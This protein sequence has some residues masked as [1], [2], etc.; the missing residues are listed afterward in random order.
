VNALGRHD[1][2]TAESLF[3]VVVAHQTLRSGSLRHSLYEVRARLAEVQALRADYDAAEKSLAAAARELEAWRSELSDRDLRLAVAQA[4][5]S[6]GTVGA[7]LPA[8]LSMFARS[9]RVA[10]AF[11]IAEERRARELVENALRRDLLSDDTTRSMS[12]RLRE[13]RGTLTL[14]DVRAALDDRTALIEYVGGRRETPTTAFVVTRDTAAAIS[15]PSLDSLGPSIERFV[16]LVASGNDPRALGRSLGASL[17]APVLPFL[18]PRVDR[19]VLVPD[20]VLYRVPFDALRMPDDRYL[21]ERAAVSIA[22][23]ATVAVTLARRTSNPRARTVVAFGDPAFAT[24]R[25]GGGSDRTVN[26]VVLDETGGLDRLPYSGR[27]ARRV[28]DYGYRPVLRLRDEASES[29]LKR[30]PWRDVAVMHFATHALVDDRVLARSVIALAPG[31]REDGF[32]DPGELAALHLDAELVVLSGCRTAGGVVLVGEGLQGLTAPLLE[33]GARAVV[34]SNWALGDRTTLPFV[35]RFY[36]GLARGMN[37]GDALRQAKLDAIR[38][39]VR[40]EQWSAFTLAGDGGTR[41][42]LR[43]RRFSPVE[44]LRDLAQ[45]VRGDTTRHP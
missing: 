29:Y 41:P 36:A 42:Q 17:I 18:S 20:G 28:A 25:T 37:G 2:A 21:V 40:I 44:W 13:R 6:W 16:T 10:A 32:L 19:L 22:P 39:G 26:R 8:V 43:S 5:G 34:A 12:R 4:R 11:A 31:E 35:D 3:A 38:D 24:E 23:S 45:P 30:T 14:S 33:A 1:Y 27:E 9:G 7:G 15:M